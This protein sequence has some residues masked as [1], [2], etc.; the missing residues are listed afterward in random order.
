MTKFYTASHQNLVSMRRSQRGVALVVALVL[1]VVVTL[2]GLASI[3]GTTM[4]Q[5][6]TANFYDR[7]I[8]FQAAE[9]GLRAGESWLLANPNNTTIIRNCTDPSLQC[10]AN[11]FDSGGAAAAQIQTVPTATFDAGA[12]GVGQPQY[13]VEKMGVCSGGSNGNFAFTNDENNQGG[14]NSLVSSGMCY[15]VTAESNA[16][17]NLNDRSNVILQVMVRL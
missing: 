3:R 13:V 10:I 6:M 8:G 11:P 2:V 17:A 7:E 15:R 12:M 14:G 9:A 4:Q 5:K 1:L 16:N